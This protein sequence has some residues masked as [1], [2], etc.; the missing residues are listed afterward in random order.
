[1]TKTLSSGQA[2]SSNLYKTHMKSW[3]INFGIFPKHC[4]S[5]FLFLDYSSQSEKQLLRRAII[6]YQGQT[7]SD[8]QEVPVSAN[9]EEKLSNT[10]WA[11]LDG[12]FYLLQLDSNFVSLPIVAWKMDE[13]NQR[14]KLVVSNLPVTLATTLLR[15]VLVWQPTLILKLAL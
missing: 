2:F 5:F 7:G 13:G 11:K 3:K 15:E 6:Q 12:F 14:A 4:F 10:L 8:K 9:W 1:M